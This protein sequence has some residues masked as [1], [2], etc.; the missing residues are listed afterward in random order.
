MPDLASL[1]QSKVQFQSDQLQ[2]LGI[3]IGKLY[4]DKGFPPDMALERLTGYT[5]I[6]KL[7]ILDGLCQWLIQHK[8]N[9]GATDKAIVRQRSSN[10]DMVARFLATG[11]VGIY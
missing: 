2:Q 10:R 7:S 11:E 4:T 8:R 1:L 5:T 3:K 6:Q 9:S